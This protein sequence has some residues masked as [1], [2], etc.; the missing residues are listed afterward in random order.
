MTR[1]LFGFTIVLIASSVFGSCAMFDGISNKGK[2]KKTADEDGEAE[3]V[4]MRSRDKQGGRVGIYL[5]GEISAH[6]GSGQ[7]TKLIVKQGDHTLFAEWE[8]S[9]T[10]TQGNTIV[11]SANLDRTVF[12]TQLANGGMTLILEGKTALR[13]GGGP[14]TIRSQ[15]DTAI[16]QAFGIIEGTLAS[17]EV[18]QGKDRL[19]IAIM[20]IISSDAAQ[21][22]YI[23]SGLMQRFVALRKYNVVERS[24]YLDAVKREVST[25][26]SGDV[27]DESAVS[28]GKQLGAAVVI[29]GRITR[30]GPS[31]ILQ[32]RAIDVT[33]AGIVQI[34]PQLRF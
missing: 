18:P 3:V 13:S 27:A 5:D 29:T 24:R 31:S 14:D 4:I 20:D 11:F 33:T 15:L 26:L 12:R 8:N 7:S 2:M 16:D 32:L 21:S 22:E 23:M 10:A 9:K 34:T 1:I 17:I 25:Q 30:E 6:L 19:T 28:I